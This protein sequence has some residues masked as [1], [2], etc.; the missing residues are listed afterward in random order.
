M[1]RALLVLVTAVGL[2]VST[3][4]AQVPVAPMIN[5]PIGQPPISQMPAISP[6]LNL[7]RGGLP[8]VNYYGIVVPQLQTQASIGL[9]QQQVQY[10]LN[11]QLG[12]PVGTQQVLNTGHSATFFNL[13]HYYPVGGFPPLPPRPVGR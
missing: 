10:G 9:L 8:A 2:G 6:F 12:G 4:S 1:K 5:T 3:A 13:S 11:N 7:T